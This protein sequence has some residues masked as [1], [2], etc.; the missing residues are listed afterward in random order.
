VDFSSGYEIE[1][2]GVNSTKTP[3]AVINPDGG[4]VVPIIIIH[5]RI[6]DLIGK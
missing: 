1:T 4:L 6:K 2:K 3:S 5:I